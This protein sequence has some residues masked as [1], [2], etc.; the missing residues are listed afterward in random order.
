MLISWFLMILL[1]CIGCTE[2]IRA[3]AI[4]LHPEFGE[5]LMIVPKGNKIGSHVAPD[6][7][8]YMTE[9]VFQQMIRELLISKEYE[10]RTRLIR[11]I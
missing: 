11:S 9:E 8:V 1:Y 3:K 7:G 2:V 6:N 5:S 4:Q 10:R